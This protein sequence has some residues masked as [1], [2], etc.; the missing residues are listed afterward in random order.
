MSLCRMSL[1]IAVLLAAP[2]AA[3]PRPRTLALVGGML[4]DGYEVPPLHHA[5]IL[6]EGERIAWV[7]RAAD[8]KIPKDTTVIDTS[9]RTMLPGLMDLHA[10]LM[11]LG[12]GN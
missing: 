12:H 2:V 4:L 5:A 11:I 3:Q 6:I 1:A 9:G 7:G 10:H 8:A